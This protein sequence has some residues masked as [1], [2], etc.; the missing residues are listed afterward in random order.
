MAING[1]LQLACNF[2]RKKKHCLNQ[3]WVI[4]TFSEYDVSYVENIISK[5]THASP[6]KHL[7]ESNTNIE[8]DYWGFN[9][10]WFSPLIPNFHL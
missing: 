5:Y 2:Y 9:I 3:N 6:Y 8:N 10:E 7:L 4:D 1:R